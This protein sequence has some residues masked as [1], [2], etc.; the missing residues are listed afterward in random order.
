[1]NGC[2]AKRDR[3]REGAG[4]RSGARILASL[5]AVPRP[6]RLSRGG[7]VASLLAA[8]GRLPRRVA[9]S[10]TL[11]SAP[12]AASVGV[13]SFA[14]VSS[15]ASPPLASPASA[16]P[17]TPAVVGSRLLQKQSRSASC[18][19]PQRCT[20]HAKEIQ[21]SALRLGRRGARRS[22]PSAEAA[23][24]TGATGRP[25]TLAPRSKRSSSASPP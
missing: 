5:L 1:M 21:S 11:R 3:C 4:G 24:R 23:A 22:A 25:A 18:L 13:C 15:S 2:N 19:A 9:T 12:L 6:P 14:G 17:P 7:V 16:S 10:P 8:A 20:T